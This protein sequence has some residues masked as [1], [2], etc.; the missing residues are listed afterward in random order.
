MFLRHALLFVL[1]VV[2]GAWLTISTVLH[3]YWAFKPNAKRSNP[4]SKLTYRI[5]VGALLG[6][7]GFFS[8]GFYGAYQKT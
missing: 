5:F 1:A 7:G 6:F 8:A 4:E 3:V 2:I